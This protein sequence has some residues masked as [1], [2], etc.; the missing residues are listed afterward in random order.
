V[1]KERLTLR[2]WREKR[3]WT[4]KDVDSRSK[5]SYQHIGAVELGRAAPTQE[6]LENMAAVFGI[7][8]S[9]IVFDES[10]SALIEA[11]GH[12]GE[13]TTLSALRWAVSEATKIND[14]K[15]ARVFLSLI[16][17]ETTQDKGHE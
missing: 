7:E 10:S 4:L 16:E 3:G 5:F 14:V 15:K 17:R 6:F 12:Y 2:E 13:P 11:P 8:V 1:Q 9:Q